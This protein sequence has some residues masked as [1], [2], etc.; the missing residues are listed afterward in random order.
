MNEYRPKLA[1]LLTWRG[2]FPARWGLHHLSIH[3]S[4]LIAIAL[5]SIVLLILASSSV[6]NAELRTAAITLPVV[7]VFSLSIRIVAQRLAIGARGDQLEIVV[8]PAGNISNDYENLSGPNML[9]YAV[10]GQSATLLVGLLGLLIL[11]AIA[12]TPA[13]GLTLAALLDFQSGWSSH[14]W[15]SQ[16]V[17]VNVFLFAIHLLPAAPFDTRALIVGWCHVSQPNWTS[18]RIS[19]LLAATASHL[20][21]GIAGFALAMIAT[22]LAA[23]EPV[24]IWYAFLLV[25]V[26]LLSVSQFE[27][28]Q[29][30]QEEELS[31]PLTRSWRRSVQASLNLQRSS[32]SYGDPDTDEAYTP[33]DNDFLPHPPLDVD[34]ILRKLHREGQEA[35]SV[36]EKDALLNASR[37][38]Q[39][40]RQNPR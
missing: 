17:W 6:A 28:F 40:R 8:G 5:T 36:R 29:A 20:A 18:A 12:P 23:H 30:Q 9:S 35:L 33:P 1:E 7:W 27:S 10:A 11:A 13:T 3:L 38:L 37:Q 34:E 26:Y 15:A 19:R 4:A 21:V 25:S 39:A 14:A 22:R 32:A 2:A 16:T 31:E 24:V